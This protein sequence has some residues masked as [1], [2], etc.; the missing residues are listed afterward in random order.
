MKTEKNTSLK[1][2]TQ[3]QTTKTVLKTI[4]Q[5]E[6]KN[7]EELQEI[8]SNLTKDVNLSKLVYNDD[9]LKLLLDAG[10][11]QTNSSVINNVTIQLNTSGSTYSIKLGTKPSLRITYF[12]KIGQE[13]QDQLEKFKFIRK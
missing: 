10:T 4:Y 7:R 8:L 13:L 5:I 3:N 11:E 9:K 1:K 2:Q 12:Y 6:F